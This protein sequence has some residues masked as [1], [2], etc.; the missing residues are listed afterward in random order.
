M[1]DR[2]VKALTRQF[3]DANLVEL[4]KKPITGDVID[5]D[6]PSADWSDANP[7][8]KGSQDAA[9]PVTSRTQTLA[10]PM[11]T[12]LLA[13]V[14]RR[15]ATVELDPGVIELARRTTRDTREIEAETLH[16][17]LR[18]SMRPHAANTKSRG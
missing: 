11:T 4:T 3:V 12:G 9:L 8:A 6:D 18:K 5:D 13:E 17:A 2:R 7:I 10:D 14:A 1:G 15:T 16:A